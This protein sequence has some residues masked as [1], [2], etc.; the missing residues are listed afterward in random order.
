LL[1]PKVVYELTGNFE[2]HPKYGKTFE[3]ATFRLLDLKTNDQYLNFFKEMVAGVGDVLAKRIID[4]YQAEDLFAAILEKPDKLDQVHGLSPASKQRL[5]KEINALL[6]ENKL[7]TVFFNA[8]LKMDFL[9]QMKNNFYYQANS[10]ALIEQILTTDFYNYAKRY[11]LTPFEE[12]DKVAM[13]FQK[14]AADDLTR[15]A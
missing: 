12:V 6:T 14:L 9:V 10:E 13:Y 4:A 5:L 2:E 8:G 15:L 11:H 7:A 3:V 1:Q